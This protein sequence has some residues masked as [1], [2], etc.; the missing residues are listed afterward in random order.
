MNQQ[1]RL[2]LALIALAILGGHARAQ[3]YS[4]LST[5]ILDSGSMKGDAKASQA[6]YYQQALDE[7][8]QDAEIQTAALKL[9]QGRQGFGLNISAPLEANGWVELQILDAQKKVVASETSFGSF[10]TVD[11]KEAV[12]DLESVRK[13]ARALVESVLFSAA[14]NSS[15]ISEL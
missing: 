11:G 15:A 5:R 8:A 9:E 3:N 6:R 14:D 12:K 13:D 1:W 10:S 4:A 2:V 7:L